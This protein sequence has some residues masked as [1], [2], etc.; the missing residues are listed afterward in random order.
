MLSDFDLSIIVEP[1]LQWFQENARVLPWRESP[2]PYRVWVSE[3]HCLN[4][5]KKRNGA[6][7]VEKMRLLIISGYR[8]LCFSRQG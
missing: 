8:K 4:G 1:L 7:P 5:T 3:I 2:T 6:Y